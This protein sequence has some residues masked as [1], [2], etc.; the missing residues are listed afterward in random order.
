MASFA[1]Y[2]TPWKAEHFTRAAS[3]SRSAGCAMHGVDRYA[4]RATATVVFAT[5]KSG[6]CED[7]MREHPEVEWRPNEP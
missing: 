4:Q 2:A 6:A 7:W 5:E 3:V 1:L